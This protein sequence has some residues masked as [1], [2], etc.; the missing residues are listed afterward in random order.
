MCLFGDFTIFNYEPH[1]FKQ[2]IKESLLVTKDK[3]LL[4]KQAKLLKL[5]L[6]SFN[7]TYAIFYRTLDDCN[8]VIDIF[9]K[10]V[11]KNCKQLFLTMG[12]VP[13]SSK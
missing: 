3:P 9:I 12:K 10:N 6:F 2:L 11:I 5:N 4:E 7:S 8:Y 1:K 13:E